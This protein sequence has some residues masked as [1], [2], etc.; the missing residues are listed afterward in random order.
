MK[1]TS[2]FGGVQFI[3]IIISIIRTKFIAIILG[4]AGVGIVGLLIS[5]T[6][7]VGRLT[8]F[9]LGTSA[10]KNVASAKETG[11]QLRISIIVTVLKRLVWIT[12]LLGFITTLILSHWLSQIAFGNSNYTFAFVW[13]SITLLL[14]QISSGQLVVLQG[15]RKLQYL[16]KANLFGSILGLVISV[17][18]YYSYGVN[19]IAPAIIITSVGNL[20]LTWYFGNKIKIEPV[21]VSPIRTFA[22]GKNMLKM[23]FVI[24]LSG[25]VTMGASYIVRIFISNTGSVEQVGLYNAGFAIINSY[26]GLIFTAM[27]TDYYPRLSAVSHSNELCK[28]TINQQAEI[29]TLILGPIIMVFLVFIQWVVIILYSNKFVS[30]NEMLRWVALGM[31]FKAAS[32]SIG[33]IFLAKGAS[34]LFFWNELIASIYMLILNLL[35]YHFMGLTGLGMSFLT[36]FLLYLIQVF[37]VSRYK[38][39]FS[40][41]SG[42]IRIMALQLSLAIT[43]FMVVRFIPNPYS[44]I[45]GS[46]LVVITVGYSFIE[47]DKRMGLKGLYKSFISRF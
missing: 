43:C 37:L 32:W 34:K 25:M 17:P 3:N 1:A 26:V 13:I 41:E 45:I 42:F 27:G 35:G 18:L 46:V 36:G 9:G 21:K 22:E 33:F 4:P 28:K 30:I 39:N 15:L 14:N 8:N 24:S 16:A 31:F 5:S 12:G 38:F 47:L 6:D 23:G 40:F 44:Y 10:V 29:A 20:I 19:A 11:N 7:L 2:L